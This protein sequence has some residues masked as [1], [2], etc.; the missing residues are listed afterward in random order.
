MQKLE[1]PLWIVQAVNALLGPPV[2]AA[3]APLGFHFEPGKVI[4]DYL[5]MCLLIVARSRSCAR[6]CARG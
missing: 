2:A 3:L 1:H 6:S 5:V 4:P